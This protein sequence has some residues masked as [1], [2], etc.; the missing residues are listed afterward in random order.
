[1]CWV[2]CWMISSQTQPVKVTMCVDE[3]VKSLLSIV[4]FDMDHI[5]NYKL[6]MMM[7]FRSLK[8]EPS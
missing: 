3:F 8:H 4:Y 7:Y 5:V 6:P 1:M 2:T